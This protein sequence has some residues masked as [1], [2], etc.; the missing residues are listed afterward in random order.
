[1][2]LKLRITGGTGLEVSRHFCQLYAT[3]ANRLM[4]EQPRKEK[5]SFLN[6]SYAGLLSVGSQV[7]MYNFEV[8]GNAGSEFNDY[9]MLCDI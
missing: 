8:F 3:P 6:P 4:M 9:K 2:L 1:M 7:R 5:S